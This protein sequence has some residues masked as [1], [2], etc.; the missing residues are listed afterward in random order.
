M[1]IEIYYLFE[2]L[3][4]YLILA[5]SDFSLYHVSNFIYDISIKKDTRVSKIDPLP[6][7]EWIFGNSV[8]YTFIYLIYTEKT[9]KL[10]FSF[11]KYNIFYT[12]ISPI[13][14]FILKYFIFYIMHRIVH[15]PVF[16]KVFIGSI[17]NID[18]QLHEM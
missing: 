8:S 15:I 1:Q 6:L 13:L 18:T 17:T 10:Y 14:Y 16:I 9:G 7:Q 4:Y 12:A 11:N 5:L 2:F 3:S